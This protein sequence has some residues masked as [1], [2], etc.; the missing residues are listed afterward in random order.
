MN[1]RM[2]MRLQDE[3][4]ETVDK[5]YEMS[6]TAIKDHSMLGAHGRKLC[7]N[8]DVY[9]MTET[10]GS[11]KNETRKGVYIRIKVKCATPQRNVGGVFISLS[12]AM[13]P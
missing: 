3:I 11:T 9:W 1:E 13:S 6:E 5:Y 12:K 8:L 4:V 10:C 7:T 2:K